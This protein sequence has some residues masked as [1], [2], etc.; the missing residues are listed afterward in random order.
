MPTHVPMIPDFNPQDR[1]ESPEF[2]LPDMFDLVTTGRMR[3]YTSR[4]ITTFSSAVAAAAE[5]PN[6]ENLDAVD[7]VVNTAASTLEAISS[8]HPLHKMRTMAERQMSRFARS[9]NSRSYRS[10]L[11]AVTSIEDPSPIQEAWSLDART[12]LTSPRR[13]ARNLERL[14]QEYLETMVTSPPLILL[15]HAQQQQY[16][17]PVSDEPVVLSQE[18]YLTIMTTSPDATLR[19]HA[20]RVWR[21]VAPSNGPRLNEMAKLRFLLASNAGF[22]SY[23]HVATSTAH[24]KNPQNVIGLLDTLDGILPPAL[25]AE[26]TALALPDEDPTATLR[27]AIRKESGPDAPDLVPFTEVLAQLSTSTREWYGLEMKLI[28]PLHTWFPHIRI[29]Y[30]DVASQRH[31]GEVYLVLAQ[32]EGRYPH[33]ATIGLYPGRY[34]ENKGDATPQRTA[35]VFANMD[36][37]ADDDPLTGSMTPAGIVELFHEHTHAVHHLVSAELPVRHGGL[38]LPVDVRET[39]ALLAERLVHTTPLAYRY[40][41]APDNLD[42]AFRLAEWHASARFDQVLHQPNPSLDAAI[43]AFM[44]APYPAPTDP[45]WCST[46]HLATGYPGT[47]YAYLWSGI[48][49]HELAARADTLLAVDPATSTTNLR[50]FLNAGASDDFDKLIERYSGSPV[51]MHIAALSMVADVGA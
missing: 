14:T 7:T 33:A 6:D 32:Y 8:T 39:P 11:D 45:I 48:Y 16:G 42:L 40:G 17:L 1:D 13:A 43:S 12:N 23:A 36:T 47:Y 28:D 41:F 37:S 50:E 30:T 20:Q 46:P 34:Y 22:E 29:E 2:T 4:C 51:D 15:T 49:A 35:L 25:A 31:I 10:L 3:H 19:R 9:A 5:N 44:D 18:L 21:S 26:A 38:N 27:Y 24:A